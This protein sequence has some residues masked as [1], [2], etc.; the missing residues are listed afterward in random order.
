[1]ILSNCF[2]LVARSVA[3][4]IPRGVICST[5][6][7]SADKCGVLLIFNSMAALMAFSSNF[8]LRGTHKLQTINIIF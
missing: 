1:M 6:A 5:K 4:S 2:P 8:K 7:F 3:C